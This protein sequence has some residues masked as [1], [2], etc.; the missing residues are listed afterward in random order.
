M[1]DQFDYVTC[2][3]SAQNDAVNY[4]ISSVAKKVTELRAE[5]TDADSL[6]VDGEIDTDSLLGEMLSILTPEII[7]AV[8]PIIKQESIDSAYPIG[9]TYVQYPDTDGNFDES[10]APASLYPGTSWTLLFNSESVFFRTEGSS[11]SESR[12]QGLQLDAFKSHVHA[13]QHT[14]GMAQHTHS[15]GSLSA[16]LP[17]SGR[18]ATTPY[19]SSYAGSSTDVGTGGY[20][21]TVSISGS[22]GTPSTDTTNDNTAQ[23]DTD[24]TGD[25]ETRPINRLM[26]IWER[27]Q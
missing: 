13:H 25:A 9:S 4:A 1:T 5:L 18:T 19:S 2:F 26:R 11:A 10:K 27:V 21:P 15:A 3:D 23:P 16:T 8:T 20:A 24:A 7:S 17:S 14:H 6:L 22:T 12:T